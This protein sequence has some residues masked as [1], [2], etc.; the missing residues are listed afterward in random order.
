MDS[1]HA[2][3]GNFA[4]LLL[5]ICV[6]PAGH[7]TSCFAVPVAFVSLLLVAHVG[8]T[9]RKKKVTTETSQRSQSPPLKPMSPAMNAPSTPSVLPEPKPQ[10]ETAP[11][12]LDKTQEVSKSRKSAREQPPNEAK[13]DVE[14]ATQPGSK[15]SNKHKSE[16]AKNESA[17]DKKDASK[18]PAKPPPEKNGSAENQEPEVLNPSKAA[19]L[20]NLDDKIRP[21]GEE[22]KKAVEKAIN[23]MSSHHELSKNQPKPP[24]KKNIAIVAEKCKVYETRQDLYTQ[25]A[26]ANKQDDTK[27]DE[28]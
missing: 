25:S 9:K 11:N 7:W 10:P 12:S 27:L 20:G 18:E 15:E 6:N 14:Q 3:F 21:H 28:D 16:Q 19:D 22:R 8:C 4:R 2:A 13:K 17:K 23:D 1:L 24:S 26:A 5:E